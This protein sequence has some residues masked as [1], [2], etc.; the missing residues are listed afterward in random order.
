MLGTS[1]PRAPCGSAQPPAGTRP[2]RAHAG[3][4]RAPPQHGLDALPPLLHPFTHPHN[5][6]TR[7]RDTA[8][9]ERYHSLAPMYYRG[10]AAA[11][12][13]FDVTHPSSFERAKK[14]V[15]ELRQNV[16]NPNL[17]IVL[18]G[19][20]VDLTEQRQ[21]RRAALRCAA[22][23]RAAPCCAA[24]PVSNGS[25]HAMHSLQFAFCAVTKHL[26]PAPPAAAPHKQG[27]PHSICPAGS[28]GG[29]A[30]L[31]QRERAAVL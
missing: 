27:P 2:V 23:C 25:A 6:P 15:W 12:V 31:R 9:Q 28:R 4:V 13:V 22:L 30:Q 10:A 26:A 29:C 5:C 16:Q 18:V 20:K 21:V 14:W 11:I 3:R 1:L 7:R 17:I 8:G 19:N 24:L